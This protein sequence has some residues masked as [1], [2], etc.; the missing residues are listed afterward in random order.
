MYMFLCGM[1][2]FTNFFEVTQKLAYVVYS[3][4]ISNLLIIVSLLR[5]RGAVMVCMLNVCSNVCQ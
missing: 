1:E 4:L 2:I 5:G 3:K